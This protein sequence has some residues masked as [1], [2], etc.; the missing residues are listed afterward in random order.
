MKPKETQNK[1]DEYTYYKQNAF[2]NPATYKTN[3][4]KTHTKTLPYNDWPNENNKRI[5]YSKLVVLWFSV[6]V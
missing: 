3:H 5:N 6:G 1:K 4:Q 2:I